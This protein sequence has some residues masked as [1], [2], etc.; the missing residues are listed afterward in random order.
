MVQNDS[1]YAAS[2]IRL[3][4]AA[5]AFGRVIDGESKPAWCAFFC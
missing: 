1:D 4:S 3:V 2:A 5:L